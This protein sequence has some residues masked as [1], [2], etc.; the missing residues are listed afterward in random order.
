MRILVLISLTL[1][2]SILPSFASEIVPTNRDIS[3]Q[4]IIMQ[5]TLFSLRKNVHNLHNCSIGLVWHTIASP[6]QYSA[7]ISV[8]GSE[9]AAIVVSDS[10]GYRKVIANNNQLIIQN[11]HDI[12]TSQVPKNESPLVAVLHTADIHDLLFRVYLNS[13]HFKTRNTILSVHTTR[14]NYPK[15][16][17]LKIKEAM[18]ITPSTLASAKKDGKAGMERYRAFMKGHMELSVDY[19]SKL[20]LPFR[21]SIKMVGVKKPYDR[22]LGGEIEN[23]A[24]SLKPVFP[25]GTFSILS[26]KDT[27]FPKPIGLNIEAQSLLE[28]I[29]NHNQSNSSLLSIVSIKHKYPQTSCLICKADSSDLLVNGLGNQEL[30]TFNSTDAS[31]LDKVLS[32]SN[33]SFSPQF[34]PGIMPGSNAIFQRI[35]SISM[36]NSSNGKLIY[37]AFIRMMKTTNYNITPHINMKKILASFHNKPIE[38]DMII[39]RRTHTLLY[40]STKQPAPYNNTGWVFSALNGKILVPFLKN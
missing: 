32:K 4:M 15:Q 40:M 20:N 19:F 7:L 5:S 29:L 34:Y 24:Y 18:A 14:L 1:F 17:S 37:L 21:C 8:D 22:V 26:A 33:Y 28:S 2:N 10:S 9:K 35:H 12:T 31:N 11:D 25:T 30:F 27:D 38:V 6:I 39:D 3:S 36:R 13:E 16:R 23:I